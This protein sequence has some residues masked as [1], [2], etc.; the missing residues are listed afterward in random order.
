MNL[1][2][3]QKEATAK[4]ACRDCPNDAD[5]GEGAYL[6]FCGPCLDDEPGGLKCHHGL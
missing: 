5:Y 6:G 3:L 1:A 2:K 4:C